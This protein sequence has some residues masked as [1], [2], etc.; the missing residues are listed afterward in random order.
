M[1]QET[2]KKESPVVSQFVSELL[3]T[4]SELQRN[5][6]IM[7]LNDPRQQRLFCKYCLKQAYQARKDGSKS[8]PHQKHEQT[9][10]L[11][12]ANQ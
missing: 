3:N 7:E 1:R 8:V 4:I 2:Q 5:G 10:R 11:N 6:E 9:C 12:P